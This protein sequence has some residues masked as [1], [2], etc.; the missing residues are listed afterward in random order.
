MLLKFYLLYPNLAVC[1][2]NEGN[3][4][5]APASVVIYLCPLGEGLSRICF[6]GVGLSSYSLERYAK[7]R[8]QDKTE[9]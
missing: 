6:I 8:M 7:T 2:S 1:I 4:A 9:I 5:I 3:L